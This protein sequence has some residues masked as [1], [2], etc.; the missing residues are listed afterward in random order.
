MTQMHRIDKVPAPLTNEE[1]AKFCE[2]FYRKTGMHFLDNKKYYVERRIHDRIAK[3]NSDNF[4]DYFTLVRFQASGEE[5][6]ALV[7]IMTVNETYF[8]REEY[9]FEALV[10]GMLPNLAKIKS[11]KNPI[12]LWS[13]PCSSGEEPYSI[14]LSILEKW[15]QA[16]RWDI[17]ILASDIDSK[18]LAEARAGIFG[19][20]S[21]TRVPAAL[22]SKYFNAK[23]DG[24]YQICSELRES[25]DFSLI[26]IMDPLQTRR[27]RNLDVIFC[28]NLLIYFDDVAR[29]ETVEMFY[30][31]LVPGGY[32]CLG[33]SE[34]MSRMTSIFIPRKFGDTIV[35]QKPQE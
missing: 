12:R 2:F 9:Q 34:S 6:Q 20:R 25:I 33:H 17:E 30:E 13:V 29:R 16:D 14:A 15:D 1:Y 19:S 35:Y 23:G 3:T 10:Y 26:N 24:N 5:L 31:L 32:V 28:R 11:S 21:L 27:F 7:N 8:F 22:I 4:R 18:I